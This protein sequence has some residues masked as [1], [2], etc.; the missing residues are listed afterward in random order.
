MKHPTLNDAREMDSQEWNEFLATVENSDQLSEM[1][2]LRKWYASIVDEYRANPVEVPSCFSEGALV[3][4]EYLGENPDVRPLVEFSGRIVAASDTELVLSGVR[5]NAEC[6]IDLDDLWAQVEMK[7]TDQ[8]KAS[9]EGDV[10]RIKLTEAPWD[11]D[12]DD[13]ATG[14]VMVMIHSDYDWVE[15]GPYMY[16]PEEFF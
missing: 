10:F 1:E 9:D 14:H 11:T 12:Y 6:R 2:I 16:P 4:V 8:S 13:L 5:R 3:T 15:S 7:Q